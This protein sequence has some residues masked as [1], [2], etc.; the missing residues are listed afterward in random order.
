M[1]SHPAPYLGRIAIILLI[2]GA[3]AGAG[4]EELVTGRLETGDSGFEI[5]SDGLI[6]DAGQIGLVRSSPRR[7]IDDNESAVVTVAYS[8]AVGAPNYLPEPIDVSIVDGVASFS[9]PLP[10]VGWGGGRGQEE[11]SGAVFK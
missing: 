6:D 3:A 7:R 10:A 11:G 1:M 9:Q 4:G 2:A 8:V 5:Y